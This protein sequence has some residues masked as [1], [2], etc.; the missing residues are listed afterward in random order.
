MKYFLLLFFC[1]IAGTRLNAQYKDTD[2]AGFGRYEA[3]NRE[4]KKLPPDERAVVFMGNS[5]T[6]E[7]YKQDST[8]FTQH[9]Y[10]NRGIGGQT[11]SQMLVRFRK[12]VIDLQPKVV[13][14]LAG[15][16]DIAGNTGYISPDNIL[17]NLISMCELADAHHITPVL[18]SVLPAADYSWSPGRSPDTVIPQ[19]NALIKD[20]A[21]KNEIVYVDFFSAMTDGHNGLPENISRDG[22]HPNLKGNKMMEKILQPVLERL[23]R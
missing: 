7:W 12:D 21:E 23:L 1:T 15:T 2:W 18:C 22:V 4:V 6:E 8:F 10:I 5:I 14:I 17:G 19:L 13:V 20:Y 16:N 3:A 9:P 11:T